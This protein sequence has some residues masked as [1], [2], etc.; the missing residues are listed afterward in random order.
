M[1]SV[2]FVIVMLSVVIL[3]VHKMSVMSAIYAKCLVLIVI[4]SVV[5]LGAIGPQKM[6]VI[7]HKRKEGF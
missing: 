6:A 4:L 1:L 7:K 2:A 3:G 5:I